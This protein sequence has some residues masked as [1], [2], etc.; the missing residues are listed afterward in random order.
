[1]IDEAQNLTH[2]EIKTI[3]SRVGEGS[4]IVLLGDPEQN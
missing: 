1:M 3:I 2:H 4:K